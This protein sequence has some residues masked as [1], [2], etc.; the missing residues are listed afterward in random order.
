MATAAGLKSSTP[1][2]PK[3]LLV[4]VAPDLGWEAL[5]EIVELVARRGIDGA[6]PARVTDEGADFTLDL[7]GFAA[8]PAPARAAY[9]AALARRFAGD[10]AGYRAALGAIEKGFPGTR[11]ATKVTWPLT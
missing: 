4:K 3:P 9:A 5:D 2:R 11:A 8:D 10:D 6:V 1:S 7:T